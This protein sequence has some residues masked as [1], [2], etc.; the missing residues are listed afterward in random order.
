MN[1]EELVEITEGRTKL[2]VPS[3]SLSNTVP[4]KVPA[5]F[6]PVARLNRDISILV[7]KTFITNIKSD[8]RTFGD[9][10]GG[11]GARSLR[12]AV[13]IPEIEHI[14]VND[15]NIFA[16]NAA[17]KAATINLVSEKCGF[18]SEDVVS[19]LANHSS[20]KNGKFTVVDLDPFG[21]PAGYVDCVLRAVVKGGLVS[22][23]ATDTAVLCGVHPNVCMR[24]YYGRSLHSTY[25]RETALRILISLISLTAAR[26]DLV[27][28]PIFVHLNHHYIRVYLTVA[29]SRSGANSINRKIGYLRDCTRCGDRNA[30]Y[31]IG[32]NDRC[33][34]CGNSYRFGGKLWSADLFDKDFVRKMICV[35][36]SE[37]DTVGRVRQLRRTLSTCLDELDDIPFYFQSDE[38]ASKLSTNPRSLQDIIE[39]LHSSGYRASRSS[40]D[41]NGFKTNAPINQILDLLA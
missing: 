23:T 25:S 22:I 2:L 18:T 8:R 7:Y 6:N 12:V 24:K 30:T 17:R 41:S 40:L 4:P 39:R 29:V 33:E 11:V 27:V 9:P 21:S 37:G 16:I 20:G 10:F 26:L 32:R 5:F 15:R 3:L 34:L 1:F 36:D 35:L 14:F 31:E 28:H 13:E 19:F 38:I